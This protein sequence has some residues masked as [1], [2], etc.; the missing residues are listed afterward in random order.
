VILPALFLAAGLMGPPEPPSI[1]AQPSPPV[2]M[3][4]ADRMADHAWR[5]GMGTALDWGS[6]GFCMWNNPN[7]VE[8]NPL[9]KNDMMFVGIKTAVAVST[10]ASSWKLERDGHSRE[11]K[12][13]TRIYF[14]LGVG[15]CGWNVYQGFNK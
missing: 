15:L 6:T 14:W 11:A 5:V 3:D 7:C 8:A 2:T 4:L 13:L 9:I 1:Y 10:M 12:I